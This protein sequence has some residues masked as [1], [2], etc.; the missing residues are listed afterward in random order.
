MSCLEKLENFDKWLAEYNSEDVYSLAEKLNQRIAELEE[1]TEAYQKEINDFCN[2]RYFGCLKDADKKLTELEEE[3][4]KLQEQLK[5]I[6]NNVCENIR[7]VLKD[8]QSCAG[9]YA[10]NEII[11]EVKAEAQKYLEE[12]K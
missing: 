2:K 6:V 3:N 9:I 12:H 11:D 4:A 1:E 10:F 5:N 7:D 8:T